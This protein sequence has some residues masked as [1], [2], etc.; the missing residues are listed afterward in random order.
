MMN[1][2][3]KGAAILVVDDEPDHLDLMLRLVEE[4][5]HQAFVA[6]SGEEA[7]VIAEKQAIDLIITDLNMPGISGVELGQKLLEDEPDRPVILM[8]AYA[9]VESARLAVAHDFYDY[10]LKPFDIKDMMST[11]MRALEHRR[12]ILE[13]KA[14]QRNLELQVRERTS[15]LNRKVME[16]KA[17]DTLSWQILSVEDTQQTLYV[18]LQ[19]TLILCESDFGVLYLVE[20]NGDVVPYAAVGLNSAPESTSSLTDLAQIDEIAELRKSRYNGIPPLRVEELQALSL[21]KARAIKQALDQKT[22]VYEREVDFVRE[23]FGVRS[24]CILPLLRY[25]NMIGLVEVGRRRKD[26]LIGVDD[27]SILKEFI[28]Y[29]ALAVHSH[30]LQRDLPIWEGVADE[31]LREAEKWTND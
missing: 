5:G 30:Q 9:D 4:I 6:R 25:Q 29:I 28:S 13:N 11:V 20:P 14:Y 21:T 18:A 10:F 17:R 26:F 31:V 16:L 22:P 1:E 24:L 27:T 7:M 2:N 15:D 8:T 3:E 23:G 12:L 19:L